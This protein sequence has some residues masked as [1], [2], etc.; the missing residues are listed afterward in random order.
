MRDTG[1]QMAFDLMS[2]DQ[3]LDQILGI[4]GQF[5]QLAGI[6][7]ANQFLQPVLVHPLPAAQLSTIAPRGPEPDAMGFQEH[8]ITP[9]LGKVQR[10]RKAGIAR[11]DNADIRACLAFQPLKRI[12]R[13]RSCRV[14]AVGI[15]SLTVIGIEQV[16][17]LT[18]PQ[19]LKFGPGDQTFINRCS[20]SHGLIT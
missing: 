1:L 12:E 18:V 6:V 13:R 9:G 11:T 3:R 17:A 16:H 7:R 5:P 15:G 10:C 8:Y 19:I 2:G 4:F 14:P 20:R